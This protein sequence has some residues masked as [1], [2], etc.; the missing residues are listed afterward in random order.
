MNGISEVST[1]YAWRVVRDAISRD[2]STFQDWPFN[3]SGSPKSTTERRSIRVRPGGEWHTSAQISEKA[4]ALFDIFLPLVASNKPFVV[5]QLGQSLDG[6]IATPTGDSYY[7]TSQP[8]R[9]HLHRLRAVCDAV[10]VGAGTVAA[11]DPQLTVRHVEGQSPVR[12]VIDPR[13]RLGAGYRVFDQNAAST[14]LI[15]TCCDPAPHQSIQ[16]IVL[17][18]NPGDSLD[19][20]QVLDALA[21]RGLRRVLVEGGAN[22]LS[23]FLAAGLLDRLHVMVAPFVI[24]SG[25]IGLNFPAVEALADVPRPRVQSYS[26]DPDTLFDLALAGSIGSPRT[27]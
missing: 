1:H 8:G 7:V 4:T 17:P 23:H 2:W 15:T 14:V 9:V 11:D 26:F 19:A 24:G 3:E 21:E 6:R 18:A 20:R 10:I 25:P 12:V 27:S 5:G 13:G 22:T 16:R